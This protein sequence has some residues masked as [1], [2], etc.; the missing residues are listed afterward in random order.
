MTTQTVKLFVE[1]QNGLVDFTLITLKMDKEPISEY[2]ELRVM[3]SLKGFKRPMPYKVEIES[4]FVN[5]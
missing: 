5:A 4:V 3:Q 2:L 1:E